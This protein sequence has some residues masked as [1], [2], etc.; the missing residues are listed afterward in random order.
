MATNSLPQPSHAANP[1]SVP[2]PR[3]R[4]A[5]TMRKLR[6]AIAADLGWRGFSNV[7]YNKAITA[8]LGDELSIFQRQLEAFYT[9]NPFDPTGE[10]Y[11]RNGG[12]K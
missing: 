11:R 8:D 2:T 4:A 1:S 10:Y 6:E 12:V 7:D 5:H 9:Y 3:E